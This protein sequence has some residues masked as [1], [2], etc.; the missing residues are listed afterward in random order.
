MTMIDATLHAAQAV[1]GLLAE[2][3]AERVLPGT[4]SPQAGA[5]LCLAASA[6]AWAGL[7][8]LLRDFLAAG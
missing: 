1:A 7:I 4:L 3:E 6:A 2:D 5:V 8:A